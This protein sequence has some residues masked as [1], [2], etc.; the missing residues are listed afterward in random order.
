MNYDLLD[1]EILITSFRS[2]SHDPSGSSEYYFRF[3]LTGL[4]DSDLERQKNEEAQKKLEK[5]IATFGDIT[6]KSL[7]YLTFVKGKGET[8]LQVK[9]DYI[10]AIVA[11]TMGALNLT[12]EKVAIKGKIQVYKVEKNYLFLRDDKLLVQVQYFPLPYKS[13]ET[14]SR[15][16]QTFLM[17][18]DKGLEVGLSVSFLSHPSKK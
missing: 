3:T 9:G 14:K 6:L 8:R 18:D 16:N 5:E 1:H 17:K 7:S 10:R 2:G 15:M 4:E 13:S 11:E 12:E